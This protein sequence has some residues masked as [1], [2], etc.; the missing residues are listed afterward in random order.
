MTGQDLMQLAQNRQAA[1]N[2]LL[3]RKGAEYAPLDENRLSSFYRIATI[4]GVTVDVVWKVLHAKHVSS[5][6]D[7]IDG[8]IPATPEMRAE[9]FG[10]EGNY[11][12]LGEALVVDLRCGGQI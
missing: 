4:A 3:V 5:I 7:M 8:R 2:N 12:L 10:D 11:G 1:N 9:K 6:Q